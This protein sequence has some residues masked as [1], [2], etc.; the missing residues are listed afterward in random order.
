MTVLARGNLHIALG[1]CITVFVH[2]LASEPN[3]LSG[4]V[5][6]HVASLQVHLINSAI[7]AG[8]PPT[9]C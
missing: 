3:P 7:P 6:T 4:A 2:M 8:C 5:C 1:E 9:L